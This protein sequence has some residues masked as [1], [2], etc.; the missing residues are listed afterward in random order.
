MCFNEG[1]FTKSPKS[2]SLRRDRTRRDCECRGGG[3]RAAQIWARKVITQTPALFQLHK[4][5][6]ACRQSCHCRDDACLPSSTRQPSYGGSSPI[7][8]PDRAMPWPRTPWLE[9]REQLLSCSK[10]KVLTP[11]TPWLQSQGTAPGVRRDVLTLSGPSAPAQSHRKPVVKPGIKLLPERPP[12]SPAP[13]LITRLR[14]LCFT[15]YTRF[16]LFWYF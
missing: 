9:F 3:P 5:Q 16:L 15:R 2:S 11:Q 8:V 12:G 14:F 6:P 7:P 10:S 13:A 4:P 1:S